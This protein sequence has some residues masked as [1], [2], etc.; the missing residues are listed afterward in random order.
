MKKIELHP[1]V[2]ND[3]TQASEYY[4]HNRNGYGV[5]FLENYVKS[6]N[7]IRQFPEIGTF[8]IADILC[9]RIREFPY[10]IFYLNLEKSIFI[11]AV[12][13]DRRRPGFWMNRMNDL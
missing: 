13:H 2:E 12:I 3:L 1:E 8:Y 5:R 11:L 4:Q 7:V 10:S 6:I 9:T